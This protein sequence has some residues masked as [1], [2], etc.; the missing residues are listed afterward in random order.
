MFRRSHALAW[1]LEVYNAL[2][3][4]HLLSQSIRGVSL[5]LIHFLCTYECYGAVLFWRALG[6]VYVP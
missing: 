2:H 5:V 3:I 6:D 1:A 4:A